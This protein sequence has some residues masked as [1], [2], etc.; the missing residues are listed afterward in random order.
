MNRPDD[1]NIFFMS[2]NPFKEYLKIRLDLI[3]AKLD[4]LLQRSE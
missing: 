1:S 3:E 2:E 4:L